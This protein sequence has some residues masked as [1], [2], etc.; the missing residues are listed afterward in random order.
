MS[1]RIHRLMPESQTE[2]LLHIPNP[3][4]LAAQIRPGAGVHR[5]DR[6]RSRRGRRSDRRELR[7]LERGA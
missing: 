1:R 5:S 6:P 3:K 2:A 4:V 7:L